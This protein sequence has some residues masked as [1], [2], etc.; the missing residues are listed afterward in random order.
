MAVELDSS[1]TIE[2]IVSL[3]QV[4]SASCWESPQQQ[5]FSQQIQQLTEQSAALPAY[6]FRLQCGSKVRAGKLPAS[7]KLHELGVCD[8]DT[9]YVVP[10]DNGFPRAVLPSRN[11]TYLSCT[12]DHGH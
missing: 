2:S 1:T 12:I 7:A 8:G 9:L 4:P 6:Y 11:S 3:L 10:T 5:Q